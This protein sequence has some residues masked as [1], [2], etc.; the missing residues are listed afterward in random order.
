MPNFFLNLGNV[1]YLV[2]YSVRDMMWLRIITVIGTMCLMPYYYCRALYEPMAWA[3]LFTIV[4]LIQ[5]GILILEERPVF[6]GD[7]ELQLYRSI[8][9]TLKPREFAKLLTIAEWKTAKIGEELLQQDQPVPALMLISSGRGS[10]EL[11]G[12]H[13]ANVTSGQ[14]VGEMGFL[15]QNNASARVVAALATEYLAWPTQKLRALLASSPAL[16]VKLQG[17]LGSDLIVKLRR[18]AHSAAHPSQ[19]LSAFRKAGKDQPQAD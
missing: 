10:V 12:R 5:I 3:T 1:L 17:I 14:F 4:N 6:F 2:A 7:R 11:D 15:T 8:F 18:E 16:H 19:L 9:Q 13:V